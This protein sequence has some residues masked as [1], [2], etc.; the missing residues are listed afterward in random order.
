ML[1]RK[2]LE[3]KKISKTQAVTSQLE[4]NILDADDVH[5]GPRTT[6]RGSR[7]AS[8]PTSAWRGAT[9]ATCR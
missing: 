8:G 5:V 4:D 6:Y 9:S 2:R 1:E 7:T 3:S